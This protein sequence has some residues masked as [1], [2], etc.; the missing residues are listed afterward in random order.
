MQLIF[1]IMLSTLDGFIECG[2]ESDL[3]MGASTL[4]ALGMAFDT[5]L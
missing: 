5:Y 2:N 1:V 3:R 4:V